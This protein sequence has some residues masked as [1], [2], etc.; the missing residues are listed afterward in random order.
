LFLDSAIE[1]TERRIELW[2][3][4]CQ[5]QLLVITVTASL[6]TCFGIPTISGCVKHWLNT[7]Q[8]QLLAITA[9]ATS[10]FNN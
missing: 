7:C 6:G 2:L 4:L 5:S 1:D 3:K 8:L 10:N 9:T